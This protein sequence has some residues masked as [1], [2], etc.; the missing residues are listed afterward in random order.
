M[1]LGPGALVSVIKQFS[2][3]TIEGNDS[4]RAELERKFAE[5]FTLYEGQ[6]LRM[7]YFGECS[8][9]PTLPRS[10]VWYTSGTVV[11]LLLYAR[12]L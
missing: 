12:V 2:D 10:S 1:V 4:L 9:F 7:G 11:H 8:S 6:R 3:F 5:L